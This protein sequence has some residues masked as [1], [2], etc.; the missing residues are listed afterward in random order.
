HA[1]MNGAALGPCPHC[2]E[3]H[4]EEML[5]CP[6]RKEQ[7]PLAGRLL[8]GKF[9]FESLLGEGGMGWV[10]KAENVLVKKAVAIKLMR[11]EF[12]SNPAILARFRNEATAAGQIGSPHICDILDFGQSDLG[13]YIV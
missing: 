2:G 1:P 13:P 5:V 4:P 9:R 6:T 12:A 10:W 11:P 7:L 8:G 3:A